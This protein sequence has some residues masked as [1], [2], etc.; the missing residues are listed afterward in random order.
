MHWLHSYR[1]RRAAMQKCK[2]YL[3]VILS[4][5]TLNQD[6]RSVWQGPE[7]SP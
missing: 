3:A 2:L 4:L 1:S 7:Q 5:G 6:E